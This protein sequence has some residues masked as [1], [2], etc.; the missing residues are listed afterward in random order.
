MSDIT[1]RDIETNGVTLHCAAAGG[2]RE[3]VVLLHGFPECDYSWRNQ[4]PELAEKFTVLAPQLR[5]FG[6]SSKPEGLENYSLNNLAGDVAGLVRAAGFEKAH[7][8]GHDWGGVIAWYFAAFWPE[9]TEKLV[10]LN[11]PHP[12]HYLRLMLRSPAQALKSW[13]TYMFQAPGLAEWLIGRSDF[14]TMRRSIRATARRK[15]H[16]TDETIGRMLEGVMAPGALTC[17]LNYYRALLRLRENR[18]ALKRMPPAQAPTLIVWAENDAFLALGN[19]ENLERW[20]TGPLRVERI[21]NC[22]HWVMLEAPE[23]VNG[24]LGSF[25]GE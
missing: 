5:G 4:I 15:E 21:E 22:G 19:A 12:V 10:V 24:L 16:L 3:L 20:T 23:E 13:Y 8:V 14:A 7:V 18:E 6:R 9:L 25:L 2:G 1:Y 11:G 17:G